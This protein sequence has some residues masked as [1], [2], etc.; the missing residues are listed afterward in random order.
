MGGSKLGRSTQATSHKDA[1][2]S[3]TNMSDPFAPSVPLV[4]FDPFAATTA[5]SEAHARSPTSHK[6][7][8]CSN[9]DMSDPFSPSAPLVGFDP[10]TA[11]TSTSEVHARSP[12]GL[13]GLQQTSTTHSV[14][15]CSNVLRGTSTLSDTAHHQ[16]PTNTCE[17]FFRTGDP[18]EP[19]AA[20]QQ[21]PE[22]RADA[23]VDANRGDS[24]GLAELL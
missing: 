18:F 13:S 7:A 17:A 10:F 8:A 14:Q 3:N 15:A 12:D 5:T 2:C 23:D 22:P 4:G 20:P 11:T 9:A 21:M 6:D 1:S 16:E 24:E 19:F